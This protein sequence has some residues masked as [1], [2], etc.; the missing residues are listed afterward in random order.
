VITIKTT[1]SAEMYLETIMML[2]KQR[3]NVRAIDI[4]HQTGYSKPSI[5]RAMSLLKKSEHI[6]IDEFGYITLTP[7]GMEVASKI[8]ERHE[9]LNKVLVSLGVDPEIA[10]V[11]A[12]R[13]EH[14]ISDETFERIKQHIQQMSG[15]QR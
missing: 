8:V 10:A 14:V 11:D 13:I 9:I 2:Q 5:S 15:E 7:Q 6:E 3:A 4:V 12:C 1:E